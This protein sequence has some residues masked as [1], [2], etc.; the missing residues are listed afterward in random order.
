MDSRLFFICPRPISGPYLGQ[1][2]VGADTARTRD[3]RPLSS[4]WP[5]RRWH[6]G[7]SPSL[8]HNRHL[9]PSRPR[10]RRPLPAGWTLPRPPPAST[11]FPHLHAASDARSCRRWWPLFAAVVAPPRP[12]HPLASTSAGLSPLPQACCLYGGEARGSSPAA[13]LPR[14]Q[15]VLPARY[16][17]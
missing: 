14:P 12:C 5:T 2:C 4:R 3:A 7:H 9:Q 10:C 17:E 15:G 1:D 11:V 16:H 8:I 13:T 6:I